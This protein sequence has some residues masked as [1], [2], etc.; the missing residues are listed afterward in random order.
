MSTR[1]RIGAL[2]VS[3]LG[4]AVGL[5]VI[6]RVGLNQLAETIARM[7]VG[8]FLLFV[9]ASIGIF[10]PLGAAWIASCPGEP[11][12]RAPLFMWARAAREAAN[13]VL[14]FS[15]LGGFVVGART[16]IA[17]G[18]AAPRVYAAMTVDITTEMASQL[19]FTL[20]G[21]AAIGTLLLDGETHHL[22]LLAWAGAGASL[23]ITVALVGLQ[24]PL[25]RLAGAIGG[26]FLPRGEAVMEAVRAELDATYRSHAAVAAAFLWNLLGWLATMLCSWL[27]LALM[28]APVS[29]WTALA[30]ES[31]ILALRSAAFMVPGGL[32]V[33]EAG[34]AL[35][36]PLLGIDPDTAVALSLVKRARD[37][38]IG[39]P[40]LIVW[41]AQAWRG[42]ESKTKQA[43]S[44]IDLRSP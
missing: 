28:G 37:L 41:N 31:L 34:Y 7:G 26:R 5:W 8:G 36:G 32:G 43:E 44:P 6:G 40:V 29:F 35:L 13:E 14:P 2:I 11:M 19:L 24:R 22:R 30:L 38:A 39:V 23:A 42:K 1:L 20:V 3:A 10:A 12:R 17:R 15:Q 21:V 33:Q 4:L 18:V 16:L 25:L 9:L 27:A